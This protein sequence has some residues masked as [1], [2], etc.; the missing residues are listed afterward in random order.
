MTQPQQAQTEE[1]SLIDLG[2]EALENHHIPEAFDYLFDSARTNPKARKLFLMIPNTYTR[3]YLLAEDQV[4][5]LKDFAEKGDALAQYTYG[6]YLYILRPNG[7]E[8]IEKALQYYE[9]AEAGGVADALQA[10]SFAMLNGH[11]GPVDIDLAYAMNLR[12]VELHSDLGAREY[13]RRLL[14]GDDFAEGDPQKAID[15]VKSRF[16]YQSQDI[17]KVNPIYYRTLGEAYELL[18]DKREAGIYYMKAV[19]M[20]YNEAY[21]D[22]CAL[23]ADDDGTEEQQAKY[24]DMLTEGFDTEDPMCYLYLAA[25]FMDRYAY[26]TEENQQE[27][28]DEIKECLESASELGN[29][30]APYFLGSAYYYGSYGFE[31]DNKKAWDWLVE[32][33]RRDYGSAY[34]LL[35]QMIIDGNNPCEVE[36][37]KACYLQLMAYRNGESDQLENVVK[38]YRNG[39]F[40]E[41]AEEIEKYY[42]PRYEALLE[43]R[44]KAKEEEDDDEDE[45]EPVPTFDDDKYKLIAVVKVNGVADIYEHD[46]E[47]G[48]D[49][50]AEI[51]GARRLDAIRVQP[52]YDIA[53]QVGLR[54]HITGWVDNVGLMNNLPMNRIGC[55]IY[56]GP[57]AGDM[58]LT[59]EDARYN[60]KSFKS[61]EQLKLVLEA[62]GADLGDVKIEDSPDDDGRFHAWS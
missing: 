4:E 21:G 57:I 2:K 22:Y 40:A 8:S 20:G 46:V 32:S 7:D 24:V 51:V 35:A 28:T 61:L 47:E 59:V 13:L 23:S 14:Y 42:V 49:E 37:G 44:A 12:A 54:D 17:S 41:Y 48:W 50:L 1:K 15:A 33:T 25:Y 6:R 53:E 52:L 27:I 38:A 29:Y 18:G 31:K 45:E 3:L 34:S 39:A 11:C 9:A 43:E 5:K 56:P 55:R 10:R 16:P 36:D 60:P 58:I 19:N 26:V 30:L 62:L